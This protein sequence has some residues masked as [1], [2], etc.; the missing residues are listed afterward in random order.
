MFDQLE[1]DDTRISYEKEDG[2]IYSF[3][4]YVISKEWMLLWR[5]FVGSD[6]KGEPPG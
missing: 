4:Y 5:N 1:K 2:V 6:G 3:G